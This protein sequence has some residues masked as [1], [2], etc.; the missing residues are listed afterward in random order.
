V[1]PNDEKLFADDLNVEVLFY[2]QMIIVT[3]RQSQWARRRKIDLA[4]LVDEPWVLTESDTLS[5]LRLK[6]AFAA[7]GLGVP[8]RILQTISSHLR[9][10]LAASGSHIT[11]LPNSTLRVYGQRFAIKALPV[12]FPAQ[13]WPAVIV[14]LKNRTL[15]PVVERFIQH[16]RDF[17]RPMR[18][19]GP[20][21]RR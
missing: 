16:V 15:S 13:S 1:K 7:R 6:E 21:R 9:V 17:T 14:T 11:T 20:A 3:G 8:K 2:E 19:G 12:D 10:N 18:D 4:E 5:Y